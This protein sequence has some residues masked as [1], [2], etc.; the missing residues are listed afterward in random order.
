MK[1]LNILIVIAAITM[2]LIASCSL[3]STPKS[4][5]VVFL[6][7]DGSIA[8][9]YEVESG[10]KV[11]SPS[12]DE[13]GV[14]GEF[15]WSLEEDGDKIYNF[16]TP[17]NS[18]ITL[19]PIE[20]SSRVAVDFFYQDGVK[21]TS[22]LY[23]INAK[24]SISD[25][26]FNNNIYTLTLTD[27]DTSQDY[28]LNTKLQYKEDGYKFECKITSTIITN[29][30]GVISVVANELKN[31]RGSYTLN[32]PRYLNGDKVSSIKEGAFST[33]NSEAGYSFNKVILPDTIT[34]IGDSAFMNC[35]NLIEINLPLGLDRISNS[36]FSGCSKL[37]SI[38]I[39][40][41]ASSIGDNAF[42]GCSALTEINVPGSVKNI[43]KEAFSGCVN[44][45][46][47]TLGNGVETIGEK[48]F[49]SCRKVE[50]I[51]IPSSITSIGDNA[52][53][54]C[55]LLKELTINMVD[56]PSSLGAMPWGGY[57]YYVDEAKTQIGCKDFI[58]VVKNIKGEVIFMS[59]PNSSPLIN[60]LLN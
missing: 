42:N 51:V 1:R 38:T 26:G 58:F 24:I 55:A 39:P 4:Y 20:K 16:D 28:P 23:K 10:G 5:N 44:I 21:I 12:Q 41:G 2:M 46:S 14:N 33:N 9:S 32:I 19:Y 17:I 6:R 50:K 56:V 54:D 18:N 47:I 31:I 49:L 43:G 3:D 57:E 27:I 40:A 13:L 29:D 25:L 22:K 11:A 45:G 15:Y 48:A 35:S 59:I 53:L 36:V 30:N 7:P 60:F 34:S 8:V 37:K 52:F